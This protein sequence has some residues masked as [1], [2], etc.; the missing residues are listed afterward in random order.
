MLIVGRAIQGIGTGGLNM[1]LDVILSNLVPLRKR[2]TYIAISLVFLTIGT[3]LGPF[4]GG[5]IVESSTWRWVFYI[6]LPVGGLSFILLFLFLQVGY[7]NNT[8]LLEKFR[9]IDLIGNVI[10]MT[11]TTALLYALT[12]GGS[13]YPWSSPRIVLSLA[14]GF[15]GI[16]LFVLFEYSEWAQ[17]PVIPLH[18]FSNRTT[19]VVFINTFISAMLLYWA[20]FFLSVYF[21][22]IL[23][24]S[25]S[26]AG[27]QM[28][29]VVLVAVP[30]AAVAVI[31]LSRF[32]RYK[33]LH[34]AGFA[35]VTIGL[36]LFSTLDQNSTMGQWV[37][38][39]II[40]AAG[41]GMVL[42]TLLPVFQAGQP[43]SDQA[44]A[45]ASWAFIRSF[46]CIWGV[47]I[48]A[49]IFNNRLQK[50]SSRISDPAVRDQL[51]SGQAYGRATRN[52]IS[53]YRDPIHSQIIEMFSDALRF[54]WWISILFSG[55][56]FLLVLLEDDIPLRVELHIEYGLEATIRDRE[57]Q[58][59]A[60]LQT[61]TV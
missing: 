36:G 51:T 61:H 40:A 11:A 31:I 23:E 46:G 28:L 6:N 15:G 45:T 56:A 1:I 33:A 25:P 34:S 49:A 42:N 38:F 16:I 53:Q 24:S 20:I 13:R 39:Q 58:A 57:G 47:T 17:E 26:R 44:A 5:A 50:L 7:Q 27:V 9:R 32:G 55:I 59:N 2:G 22:A 41:T 35:F 30:G 12:Y 21:Q 60:S 52:Y 10:L 14:F 48:P 19:A 43:E 29:P 18:L 3:S 54:V 8:T 4:I 37:I